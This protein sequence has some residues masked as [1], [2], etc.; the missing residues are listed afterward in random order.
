MWALLWLKCPVGSE[1]AVASLSSMCLPW[2]PV[3]ALW[4]RKDRWAYDGLW[5]VGICQ[6]ISLWDFARKYSYENRILVG[7]DNSTQ[8]CVLLPPSLVS[9]GCSWSWSCLGRYFTSRSLF[10]WRSVRVCG[11]CVSLF[12]KLLACGCSPSSW[13]I[14]RVRT[15]G[16]SCSL[17]RLLALW[18]R[19]KAASRGLL[20]RPILNNPDSMRAN[21]HGAKVELLLPLKAIVWRFLDILHACVISIDLHIPWVV[22][23]RHRTISFAGEGINPPLWIKLHAHTSLDWFER[24][25]A[26]LL[27]HLSDF[28][29]DRSFIYFFTF[30]LSLAG[31]LFH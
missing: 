22:L 14:W 15:K 29:F 1:R 6:F 18:Q 17:F 31:Y 23:T 21:A 10:A 28:V 19:T 8:N 11:H 3:L 5:R 20:G 4:C 26:T 2:A 30:Q 9:G 25:V 16:R 13:R 7:W 24:P 12:C 27:L